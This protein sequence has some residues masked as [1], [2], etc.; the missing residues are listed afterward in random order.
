MRLT[1]PLMALVCALALGAT[2]VRADD[3]PLAGSKINL[4]DGKSPSKRR[5]VFVG[6]YGGD[7]GGMNPNFDGASLR[8]A[9]G[10]GEGDSG[11][12][13][14]G[15]NWKNLPKGKGFRYTDKTQSA[16]GIQS[17]LLRKGKSGGGRIKVTGGSTNWAYQIAMP[18]TT[19][20]VTLPLG[21][22]KPCARPARPRRR[23][24]P[25]RA[26][27][28]TARGRRSRRR[29]SSGTAAPIRPAMGAPP[30]P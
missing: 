11:L 16:G 25:V 13:Q 12:I 19:I 20:T 7:L 4:K 26:R 8:V 30:A 14:L 24:K 27:S 2:T 22:A 6:K 9:G 29:S 3:F 23:S 5:I 17:I 28:S 10:P 18:Q 15:P 1:R 21:S